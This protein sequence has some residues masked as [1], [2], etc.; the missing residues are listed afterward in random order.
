M[1][2]PKGA[3]YLFKFYSAN[4]EVITLILD[5]PLRTLIKYW[6]RITCKASMEFPTFTRFLSLL[7]M[8]WHNTNRVG[9][10]NLMTLHVLI[11]MYIGG[12]LMQDARTV[13]YH[14]I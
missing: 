8:S 11:L 2:C 9:A 14:T 3:K 1:N 10:T 5:W 7:I 12:L 6:R 4:L 13:I